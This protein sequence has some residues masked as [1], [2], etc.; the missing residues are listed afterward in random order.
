MF[1]EK[2]ESSAFTLIRDD[3]ES[4]NTTLSAL[5]LQVLVDKMKGKPSWENGALNSMILLNNQS[6]QIVLTIM[7]EGTEIVSSQAN[8]SITFRVLEG[9]LILHIRNGSIALHKGE[10]LT[11]YEKTKYSIKSLEETS[12]L[13]TL[14]S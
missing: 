2:V 14:A 3:S 7:H 12:F 13:L 4:F 9:E 6:S 5:E 11:L 8:D 1:I 10:I